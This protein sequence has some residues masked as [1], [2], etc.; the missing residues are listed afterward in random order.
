MLILPRLKP[1]LK[2][3]RGCSE[4]KIQ[5]VVCTVC[6]CCCDDLKVE[7]NN[8]KITTVKN[9]CALSISKLTHSDN[10]LKTPQIRKNNHLYE[11]S[12]D[13][14]LDQTADILVNAKYPLLWGWSLTSNETVT[15]GVELAEV[16]GGVI[17]NNTSVCH[18]PGLLG[19]HDIGVSSCTLGQVKNRADLIVYWG[20]NPVHA[21]PR[22]MSRYTVMAQG[23]FRKTRK[24]R[25]LIV[26]DVRRTDTA[27][28][29][30][31]FIQI[32]PGGDYELLTALRC[33]V[34]GEEI[35]GD[36][37]SGVSVEE[38]EE[39]ADM[40]IR[41]EFGAL[42]YGVGLTMSLGKTR[43][44]DIALSLVRDLNA[45]TKFIILPVR[46][47]FN[48]TGSNEVI[49]WL[50]GYPFA[51]DFSHRYPFYNPGDT[52]AV[53][54]LRRGDCDA[55]FVLASDPAAHFPLSVVKKIREIPL[56]S[57][58]P[59]RSATTEISNIA[60]PSTQVGIETEGMVYRM[61]GVPLQ[62]K[63]L[64]DPQKGLKTDEE[65]LRSLLERVKSLKRG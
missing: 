39:L 30:D 48:V 37:V 7:V 41:C 45:R 61:D 9:A 1:Y 28:L 58:D 26:V 10:R 64:V 2:N 3:F 38:I 63:K 49:T 42:F 11:V 55:M 59:H 43:N 23:H 24:E 14:A 46:G 19:I 51:V 17:D 21:H 57:V 29:A 50:T 40:L 4:L 8:N 12:Y 35:E 16:V 53:D 27:K 54:I 25:T 5:D 52:T 22:H 44:I 47:H 18:G 15:L 60:I 36:T 62:C 20:S 65:I 6:G 32:E 13:E 56:I 31:K 34:R 33:A